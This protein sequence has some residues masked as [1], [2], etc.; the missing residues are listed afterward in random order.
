MRVNIKDFVSKTS[1]K[2]SSE[3]EYFAD[4]ES[5]L[6]MFSNKMGVYMEDIIQYCSKCYINKIIQAV[7]ASKKAR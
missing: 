7:D 2:R 6:E 1:V 4:A 5:I 3:N